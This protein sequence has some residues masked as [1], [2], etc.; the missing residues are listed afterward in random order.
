[1]RELDDHQS[2][3]IASLMRDSPSAAAVQALA[4]SDTDDG[5]HGGATPGFSHAPHVSREELFAMAKSRDPYVRALVGAR[6]DCPLG[7]L[8]SLADDRVMEV[9][10]AVAGNPSALPSVLDQLAR[11]KQVQVILHVAANP[12]L[13]HDA[14]VALATNKHRAVR[15]AVEARLLSLVPMG[16]T[17]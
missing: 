15:K 2:H 1:M 13:P 7:L 4:S 3:L 10:L 11:D 14:L 8:I 9:R 5:V 12:S 6:D 16:V 17:R